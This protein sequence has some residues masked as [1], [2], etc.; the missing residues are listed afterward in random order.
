ML[1]LTV[2]SD[3]DS[4]SD[5]DSNGDNV[6]GSEPVSASGRDSDE[7]RNEVGAVSKTGVY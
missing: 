2:I 6:V 3:S 7:D 4:S 5:S 1:D